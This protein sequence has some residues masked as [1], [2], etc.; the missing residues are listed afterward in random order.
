MTRFR[1]ATG[2]APSG[3]EAVSYTHL[4]VYKRQAVS[5][6]RRSTA[7]TSRSLP[8]AYALLASG[9][10]NPRFYFGGFFPRKDAERRAVVESLRALDAAPVSYTH[11]DVYKRQGARWS[12]LPRSS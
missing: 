1:T 10:A 2:S 12:G 6:A 3:S 4:D 5:S 7:R 9:S 8:R 11:L